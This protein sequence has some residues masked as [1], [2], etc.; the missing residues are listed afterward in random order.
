MSNIVENPIFGAVIGQQIGNNARAEA[1]AIR[2]R[3]AQTLDARK[4]DELREQFNQATQSE[5]DMTAAIAGVRGVTRELLYA[6]READPNHP[7]LDKKVRDKVWDSCFDDIHKKLSG[8]S[9]QSRVENRSAWRDEYYG[10]EGSSKGG[11]EKNNI[12]SS[13]TATHGT[14]IESHLTD[15]ERFLG[16]IERLVDEV[17]NINPNSAILSDKVMIDVF[18]TH[19]L[20]EMTKHEKHSR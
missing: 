7:L 1:S 18:E 14:D 2:A 5:V 16:L 6:L 11:P 20:H 15:R 9:T 3:T 19:T 12:T 8:T 10:A 17:R 4:I 13:K